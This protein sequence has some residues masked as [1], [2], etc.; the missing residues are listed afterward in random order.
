MDEPVGHIDFYPNGGETQPGC[1]DSFQNTLDAE[2][3]I[4]KG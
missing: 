4:I 1:A 2:E 3:S